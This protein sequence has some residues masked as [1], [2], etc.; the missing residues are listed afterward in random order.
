M[1]PQSDEQIINE[2]FARCQ[3]IGRIVAKEIM[4]HVLMRGDDILEHL[5]HQAME[6]CQEY[7]AEANV[8]PEIR[9]FCIDTIQQSLLE[10]GLKISLL[11]PVSE[12]T[13]Q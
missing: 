5:F 8:S 10:E 1:T 7:L 9:A 6:G 2:L 3:N 4:N 12:A 13:I 11:L